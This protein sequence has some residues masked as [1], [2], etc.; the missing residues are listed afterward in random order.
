[1]NAAG[2]SEAESFLRTRLLAT[3]FDQL[4]EFK[5][6]TGEVQGALSSIGEAGDENTRRRIARLTR[7]LETFE[8]SVTMIGQ[9]KSGKT[10]LVNAFVGQPDLLPADVNPWTSVVTSLHL[11]PEAADF[12]NSASFRFFDEDE[13]DRLVSGGGRIGELASRAGADEELEKI[14]KQVAEM[15]EK[16]RA[17]LGR[18]FEVMLGQQ[19]DYGYFDK[20][21][22]ERYVCL[23]D[24]TDD[25]A[26]AGQDGQG[27]FADI[28]KSA[29]LHLTRPSLPVRICIRDTPGVNDTFMMR[30]QITIRAIRDSRICV[31]VLS[32]HQALSSADLALIRLIT[33]VRSRDVIIFVNRIDELSDPASEVPMIARSISDTLERHNGPADAEVIFGSALWAS[34]ALKGDKSG[35]PAGSARALKTRSETAQ[36]SEA[37]N[38]LDLQDPASMAWAVSGI[39]ELQSAVASRIAAGLGAAM[40]QRTSASG[41]NL[42][43]SITAADQLAVKSQNPEQEVH[44]DSTAGRQQVAAIIKNRKAALSAEFD[45]ITT[46]FSERM[47]RV[48]E[49]FLER[50]T[51]S[52]VLHLEKLG[53]KVPWTYDP[54]GLRVLLNSSHKVLAR[55]STVAFDTAIRSAAHDF[56]AVYLKSFGLQPDEFPL[57]LPNAPRVPPPVSLGRTIALD[58][59]GQWWKRWWMQ[60]RGYDAYAAAFTNLIREE[61]DP[62]VQELRDDMAQDIRHQACADFEAFL[63]EQE[64]VFDTLDRLRE[65]GEAEIAAFVEK[66]EA[67]AGK[68][69]LSA[70]L[71]LLRKYSAYE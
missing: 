55:K 68:R 56:A 12:R 6:A 19:R 30:E 52:L 70:A 62:V 41:L 26:A 67:T 63:S 29:D 9:I 34:A 40:L 27:R 36:F 18:K 45:A 10:S 24:E 17:R 20:D 57:A 2:P 44:L 7:Q 13:W 31:V 22:I 50:A 59:Q 49:S 38:D 42:A 1:M 47:N 33:H 25:N 64:S 61:T 37:V 58:L 65:G 23:G 46:A 60:R 32:A 69:D 8:P 43:T 21:L 15:R 39:P 54:A 4:R 28:T 16:S 71:Q 51:A 5:D 35:L 11:Y 66:Q 48:Q 3:G 14:K 53:E